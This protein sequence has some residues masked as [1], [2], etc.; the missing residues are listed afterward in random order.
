[1]KASSVS[2]LWTSLGINENSKVAI[3]MTKATAEDT[4]AT[5]AEKFEGT[6][7]LVE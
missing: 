1:L 2:V 7:G 4:D 5:A 6:S 3:A